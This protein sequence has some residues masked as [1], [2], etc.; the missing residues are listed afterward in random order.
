MDMHTGDVTFWK[1]FAKKKAFKC[2]FLF[3]TLLTELIHTTHRAGKKVLLRGV[4]EQHSEE[5]TL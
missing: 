1:A 4:S 3:E 2:L 5:K